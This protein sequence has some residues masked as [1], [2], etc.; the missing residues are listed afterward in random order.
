MGSLNECLIRLINE[1]YNHNL[2]FELGYEYEK[3]EQY[4]TAFSYYL[5]CAEF[6]DDNVLASEALIRCSFCINKQ[7]NRDEKEI[8]LIKHAITA[9][10]N[11]IEPYLIASRFYSWR[12]GKT[13]E[14]RLWLDAY[15]YACMGI[16]ILEN[17]LQEKSFKIDLGYSKEEIYRQREITGSQIGK[18]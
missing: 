14:T 7:N 4:A 15:M 6:T 18:K 10:P 3:I 16:N 5:R 13:P 8:Y 1:P 12:S 11:S 9:S 2:N 17:N